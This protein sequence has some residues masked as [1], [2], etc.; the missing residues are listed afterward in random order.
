MEHRSDGRLKLRN[1]FAGDSYCVTVSG[2]LERPGLVSFAAEITRMEDSGA[3]QT[4][5]D[6]SQV[7]LID[8]GGMAALAEAERR[9]RATGRQLRLRGEPRRFA[10]QSASSSGG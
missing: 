2:R 9:F 6:L 10:H 8:A 4:L 1:S 5:V 3:R 7:E